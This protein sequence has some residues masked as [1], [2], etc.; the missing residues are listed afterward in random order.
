MKVILLL[1]NV[2]YHHTKSVKGLLESLKNISLKYIPPYSSELNSIEHLWKDIRKNVTHNHL[3]ESIAEVIKASG[4]QIARNLYGINLLMRTVDGES[5][6]YMYNG[7]ADVTALVNAATGEVA[8]TY[9]YDAFGN[10]LESTGD[11]NNNITYAGYQYDEETGLYY[12]NARMYEPKI[13]R[14]LQ[15]D[16]Y[17]G[18]P[19]DP[20]SLN[21]YAYCAYNP[22]V[23]YDPT[24]HMRIFGIEFG[25]PIEGAKIILFGSEE[26]RQEAFELIEEYGTGSNFEK[27]VIGANKGVRDVYQGA[28]DT[29]KMVYDTYKDPVAT[30]N[31]INEGIKFLAS[32]KEHRK[33]AWEVTK[34][35][36]GEIKNQ[37]VEY[38]KKVASGDPEAISRLTTN[39]VY[40]FLGDKGISSITGTNKVSKF[41]MLAN[42]TDDINL[43]RKVTNKVDDLFGFTRK[44]DDLVDVLYDAGAG[45]KRLDN[46]T[47][48]LRKVDNLVDAS[49]GF[50][51][52]SKI[53]NIDDFGKVGIPE[54]PKNAV[55]RNFFKV[56]RK[57]NKLD[58]RISDVRNVAKKKPIIIGENMKRVKQYAKEIGG[59]AY[60]PWKNDP[61]DFNLAMKRNKRW[62]N[63]M[64]KEGREIIDIGPDFS[65][66]SLGRDPSPFYNMERS[67]VKGYSNYKKVFERDGCLS[68]GVK[69]F[70]R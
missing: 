63:D 52:A 4:K 34:E 14:F 36:G 53:D 25:N 24:G 8:A 70:D 66:R 48:G 59:H 47:T 22:I 2:R 61:F 45:M 57:G 11:V 69:D 33:I 31:E 39:V 65:R 42:K 12:L 7:H 46:V 60:R 15:E 54:L 19:M 32:D 1:D 6:Y 26:E 56:T 17:R 62:I 21:L 58:T 23:Y 49:T 5:Y 20:L 50:R 27:I 16:T 40:M 41:S 44:A 28:I 35:M 64:M 51:F 18:D 13:A 55:Q 3:F 9:Y 38:S 29:G 37:V 43:I 30:Y 67:Q 10:I 68:G